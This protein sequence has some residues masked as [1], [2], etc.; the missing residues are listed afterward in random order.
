MLNFEVHNM[1][2]NQQGESKTEVVYKKSHR[3]AAP[4]KSQVNDRNTISFLNLKDLA[5]EPKDQHWESIIRH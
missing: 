3:I 1:T 5:L 2:S 4:E